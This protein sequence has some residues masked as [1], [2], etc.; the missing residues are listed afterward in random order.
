MELLGYF[1]GFRFYVY[2]KKRK[3]DPI[4]SENRISILIA[5]VF[6]ALIG[7]R[8]LGGLENPP[9]LM[10]SDNLFIYFY[11]NK[12]VLGGLLGGLWAVEIIKKFIGEKQSSGDLFVY[13]LILAMIIGR[14][15]CFSMGIY[16]ETYGLPTTLPWGMRLG[17][18]YSRHPVALYEM[19][20]LLVLWICLRAYEK[21][22]SMENGMLFK[23]FM[24][25]YLVFRCLLDFIKPHYTWP[26][27]LSS[28]QI[29]CLIGLIYYLYILYFRKHIFLQIKN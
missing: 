11:K 20:Y 4:S 27:G 18:N 3:G 26:I 22:R 6:G 16:E 17:D 12:T 1:F 25:T 19:I 28:I 21:N 13:P 14:M 7:S 24:I 8:L 9:A 23:I 29:A 2:L 15:G 10:H 5:A